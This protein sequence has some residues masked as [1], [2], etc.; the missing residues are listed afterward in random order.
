MRIIQEAEDSLKNNK[1]ALIG[2]EG[3]P[4]ESTSNTSE[5]FQPAKDTLIGG[6][7]T[8]CEST[9]SEGVQPDVSI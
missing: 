2:G 5:G 3:K 8:P 7:V 4:C 6:E 9:T 1:D